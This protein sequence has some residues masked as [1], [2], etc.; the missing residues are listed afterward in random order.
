L[1]AEGLLERLISLP[2]GAIRLTERFLAK[3]SG[4]R[5]VRALRAAVRE[6]IR[7]TLPVRDWRGA[8]VIGSGGTFTSLAGM[9]LARRGVE[10][11][12]TTH[13]TRVPREELEH[14]LDSLST[15]TPEERLGVQ[16]LSPARVDIIVAGLAVAAEVLAR[17]ESREL[18]VSAYGIR[19]GLLLEM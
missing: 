11:A 10:T 2:F 12:R 9:Y 1:S 14:I 6:Q 7:P 3:G 19:E 15:L 4:R 8:Q 5:D 13:A 17:L 18:V 16:G